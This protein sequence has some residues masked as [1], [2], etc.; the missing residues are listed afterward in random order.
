M[1]RS[2]SADM[3]S[4][5]KKSS[6]RRRVYFFESITTCVPEISPNVWWG[7]KKVNP[8]PRGRL[9][10][11]G[12]HWRP[13]KTCK[14]QQHWL[15]SG[16]YWH[17]TD[18]YH[19]ASNGM[20]LRR[21]VCCGSIIQAPKLFFPFFLIIPGFHARWILPT[22]DVAVKNYCPIRKMKLGLWTTGC[23]K[24]GPGKKNCIGMRLVL[25]SR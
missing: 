25:R 9:R 14:E 15:I 11:N 16:I 1:A 19:S 13:I 4:P 20:L 2:F 10:I 18:E 12:R 23:S 8:K 17:I 7:E 5:G 21:S 6:N 3:R 22:E 24:A